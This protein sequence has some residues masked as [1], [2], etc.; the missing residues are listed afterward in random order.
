MMRDALYRAIG[1]DCM[2]ESG[3]VIVVAQG[4]DDDEEDETHNDD[5]QNIP[6]F[7]R[8][9]LSCGASSLES[10]D[11]TIT[12]AHV[13]MNEGDEDYINN[14][15]G[16][17]EILDSIEMPPRPKGFNKARM[18][19][20]FFEAVLQVE[21]PTTA[22]TRIVSNI[23]LKL[24]FVPQS[25][26]EFIMKR[27]CGMMVVKLQGA[28]RKIVDKPETNQHAERIRNDSFYKHWMLPKFVNY[29][30][31]KGWD[32]P[33]VVALDPKYCPRES[34]DTVSAP[35]LMQTTEHDTSVGSDPSRFSSRMK[36]TLQSK[37]KKLKRRQR[38]SSVGDLASV[39]SAPATSRV[40]TK[41]VHNFSEKQQQRLEQL[42]ALQKR[43]EKEPTAFEEMK[44]SLRK[45]L[46]R[47]TSLG[48]MGHAVHD[49]SPLLVLP[50]IFILKLHAFYVVPYEEFLASDKHSGQNCLLALVIMVA[51]IFVHRYMVETLIVS[52][53][54]NY[55]LPIPRYTDTN[56]SSTT[57]KYY[58][59]QAQ[60]GSLVFSA[61][62]AIVAFLNGA[63][64]VLVK[65]ASFGL[66]SFYANVFGT[67]SPPT[68]EDIPFF[69][70]M[71]QNT[72]N[73]MM[74]TSTFLVVA[75]SVAVYMHPSKAGKPVK[76]THGK[77]SSGENM[78]EVPLMSPTT[79]RQLQPIMEEEHMENE[80]TLPNESAEASVS[81][82]TI[83]RKAPVL[84]IPNFKR[85]VPR[86]SLMNGNMDGEEDANGL[87]L[88]SPLSMGSAHEVNHGFTM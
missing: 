87:D 77:N 16:K 7:D 68:M 86:R 27:M 39:A 55:D 36:R 58:I 47:F 20:K 79:E 50:I 83:L 63:L 15:L 65:Y 1:C 33:Q 56:E 67:P 32:M 48:P 73:M 35:T 49:Y 12:N 43:I 10:Y 54:D 71:V 2:M 23:D 80:E 5:Q 9:N 13:E 4:I 46:K 64:K 28:A 8:D 52:T 61:S 85:R 25:I 81:S 78:D 75:C 62:L 53:L 70:H 72:H 24:K 41:Y 34:W 14:L 66:R 42:K 30:K 74:Y 82:D 19:V 31:H 51:S 22:T 84:V 3:E 17:E 29:C 21:S 57:R 88:M 18:K 45:P 76:I 37:L 26:I 6:D 60:T 44:A 40:H 69:L 59:K 11:P 38:G